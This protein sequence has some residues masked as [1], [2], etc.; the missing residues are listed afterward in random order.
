MTHVSILVP[1]SSVLPNSVAGLFKIFDLANH[2]SAEGG[3][4]AAFELHLVGSASTADLYGGHFVV[5][6]DLTLVEDAATDLAIIPAMAG[7]IA[8]AINSNCTFIPWIQKQYRAGA[9][10]AGL[11][12]GACFIADSGLMDEKYCSSHWFVDATFRKQYSRINSVAEKTAVAPESIHSDSGAWFFL[13]KFLERVAGKKAALA[14]SASFQEPFNREC[15][16]IVSV[17]DPRRRHVNRI[18][19]KGQ[20]SANGDSMQETTVKRF[21]SLFER[22][23]EDREG[24]FCLATLFEESLQTPVGNTNPRASCALSE[25]EEQGGADN[26]NTGTFKALFKKLKRVEA[27]YGNG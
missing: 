19:K 17:S 22:N 14:C 15:Q 8:R 25:H 3:R 9:E 23:H 16:S 4:G 26:H 10:I 7:D 12:T 27:S 1:H 21:I 6:P 5:K 11:C 13:H 20:A 2:H 24:S 18:A